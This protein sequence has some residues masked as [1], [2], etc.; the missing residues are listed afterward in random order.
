MGTPEW[1]GSFGQVIAAP[2]KRIHRLP[3]HVTYVQGAVVEPLAVGARAVRRAGVQ[4]GES[5]AILGTE[6]IGMMVCA[7]ANLKRASKIIAVD[8]QVHC[9]D[10]ARRH[11]GATD[12]VLADGGSTAAKIQALTDCEGVDVVFLTVGL[13]GLMQEA[14]DSISRW[15][16]IILVALFDG[17]LHFEAFEIINPDLT[18][19]GTTGYSSQDFADALDLI[20]SGQ[21]PAEAMVSHVLPLDQAQHGF[22]LAD[23]KA[24]NAMKVVLDVAGRG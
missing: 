11:L 20:A 16:R 1:P 5:V 6:P 15:G 13:P 7:A 14:F 24:D 19:I 8:R 18:V 2:A 22:E 12:T 3:D 21:V 23:T 10:T 9:L 17:P 4:E